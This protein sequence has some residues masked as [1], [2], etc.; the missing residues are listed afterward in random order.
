MGTG[1]RDAGHLPLNS[2]GGYS[3]S[4][5]NG[6]AGR[7]GNGS[8]IRNGYKSSGKSGQKSSNLIRGISRTIRNPKKTTL[9]DICLCSH[10]NASGIPSAYGCKIYLRT[11]N[12]QQFF[13]TGGI[14]Y[15]LWRIF[16]D[17]DQGKAAGLL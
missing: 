11:G 13:L 7:T 12:R 9:A 17:R 10:N 5:G 3:G 4:Y 16:L 2:L 1:R 15:Y 8:D 6:A 14:L